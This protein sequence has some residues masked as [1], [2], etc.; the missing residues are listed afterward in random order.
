[1]NIYISK[2]ALNDRLHIFDTAHDAV[3]LAFIAVSRGCSDNSRV[4]G[5]MFLNPD[6]HGTICRARFVV[7]D[8]SYVLKPLA[9]V[10]KPVFESP[11]TSCR[12][13]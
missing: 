12:S 8:K 10:L 11:T 6:L 9:R 4:V 13:F 2:D 1:M 5:A 7:Y 3:S